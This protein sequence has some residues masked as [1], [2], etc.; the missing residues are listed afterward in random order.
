MKNSS[1]F[2]FSLAFLLSATSSI[3]KNELKLTA[4][5]VESEEKVTIPFELYKGLI[6]LDVEIDGQKG[7]VFL[8][9]GAPEIMLNSRNFEGEASNMSIF[10][11]DG[12]AQNVEKTYIK[13]LSAN[14]VM[15]WQKFEAMTMDMTH[16]EQ[17]NRRKILGLIGYN[18]FQEHE[19][20]IDYEQE[21]LVLFR[22]DKKGNRLL[23]RLEKPLFQKTFKLA[24]HLA[25]ITIKAG[26]ELLK[27]ALDTG[28]QSNVIHKKW[29]KKLYNHFL[30][31]EEIKIIGASKNGKESITG[32]FDRMSIDE[33]HF[34]KMKTIVTD[35]SYFTKSHRVKIDGLLG[36]EFLK[37][38]QIS[39][40]YKKKVVCFWKAVEPVPTKKTPQKEVNTSEAN[41]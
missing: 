23:K 22:L 35:L 18:A 2:S 39:I 30:T 25:V 12:K 21:E 33:T 40:N 37:Q 14:S 6:F 15:K 3:A 13:E 5:R 41:A 10:G 38:Y 32:I 4:P 11:V 9:T 24:K 17:V 8:D 7:Q 36:Y 31:Y 28:A 16:L 29:S 27:L 20:L 1:I 26:N 34:Y 19:L